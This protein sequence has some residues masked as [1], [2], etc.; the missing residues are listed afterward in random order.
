MSEGTI[1]D[2]EVLI[3]HVFRDK[4]FIFNA[5]SH[6]S[7][8]SDDRPSNE[9]L[10]FLG[11]SVLGTLLAE[12]LYRRYADADEGELT[13]IK[14]QAVSRATL[15]RVATAMGLDRYILVGKGVKK[16]T[17]PSSLL[18]NLFEAI[19]G[20][21]YLDAGLAATRKFVL[22]HLDVIVDEIVEDRAERN[23]KSLLQ[24]YC[25]RELGAMPNY[26][27][28]RESGPAHGRMYEIAAMIK[29]EEIGL[30]RANSKKEAEQ[31]AARAAMLHYKAVDE[32]PIDTVRGA[33]TVLRVGPEGKKKKTRRGGRK[34]RRKDREPE[35]EAEVA[36]S[37]PPE[38]LAP[39]HT[40]AREA[41]S[42]RRSRGSRGGRRRK[43]KKTESTPGAS[44][45][46]PEP[47]AE[48]RPQP[49]AEPAAEPKPAPRKKAARK[50]AAKKKAAKKKAVRKKAAKKK[51][52]RKKAPPRDSG[53]DQQAQE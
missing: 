28:L 7:T 39:P 22:R 33:G 11:D 37:A 53:G 3:G 48:P 43:K 2:L 4:G 9:R 31:G 20:A 40:P 23:Y 38:E 41:E 32:K 5:L 12:A 18:G 52:T 34:R 45:P 6:S 13:R 16:K 8:K 51:A 1:A 49:R 44:A 36:S 15:E 35:R 27:V 21:I 29:G 50:K 46:Q 26:R 42:S 10:E 25:Q 24:H 19:V 14:S 47:K 17:I 30:A